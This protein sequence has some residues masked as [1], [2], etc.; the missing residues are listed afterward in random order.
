MGTKRIRKNRSQ[1]VDTLPPQV[2]WL[3]DISMAVTPL[4]SWPQPLY[5]HVNYMLTVTCHSRNKAKLSTWQL[6]RS[7][8]EFRLLRKRLMAALDRGHFCQAECPWLYTF[9][10]SYYP[11][12]QLI[13]SSLTRVMDRRRKKL[14]RSLA[15]IR[16]FLMSKSNHVCPLVL[17]GVASELLKFVVGKQKEFEQDCHGEALVWLRQ[18]LQRWHEG[19]L[20]V[21]H[22]SNHS[23]MLSN[24]SI[25]E[26]DS[27]ALCTNTMAK[28]LQT[29][30]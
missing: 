26:K 14:T 12:S 24:K 29:Q 6:V 9:L 8:D 19:D 23:N 4:V 15:T 16:S 1:T 10:K 3:D 22:L 27:S 17:M 5:R 13:G 20:D 2:A 25:I 21:K 11:T 7:F 28:H 30:G 18:L